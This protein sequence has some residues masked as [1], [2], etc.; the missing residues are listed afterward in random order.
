M[1]KNI[2]IFSDG[3]GQAG[4]HSRPGSEQRLQAVPRVPGYPGVQETFYDPGLGSPPDGA[5]WRRWRQIY[6]LVSQ[7]TGLGISWN[8]VDC[9][10]A[11]IRMYEPGDRIYL[12]GFSRGCL[13][14]AQP[15][16]HARDVRHSDAQSARP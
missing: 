1:P 8:I 7:A 16:R 9:Y 11:L 14:R 3:T 13:H 4:R 5:R 2:V 10:D 6:N 15:R 12:F